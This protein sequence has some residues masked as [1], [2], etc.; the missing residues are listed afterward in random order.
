[1]NLGRARKIE[2]ES[3]L[4]SN[5]RRRVFQGS[6]R[7]FVL[8]FVTDHRHVNTRRAFISRQSHIGN[9]DRRQSRIFKLVTDNLSNLFFESVSSSFTPVHLACTSFLVLCLLPGTRYK[10]QSSFTTP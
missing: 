4:F 6:Q 9:R 8:R 1:M 10:Q 5:V 2:R 3:E 7:G